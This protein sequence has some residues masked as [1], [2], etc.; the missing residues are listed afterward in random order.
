[1]VLRYPPDAAVIVAGIPGAGKSTLIASVAIGAQATVLDTDPRRER[2]AARLPVPYRLWRPLLHAA[3]LWA[4]WRAL[5]RRG[6]VVIGEPGTRRIVRRALL[7]RARR[8]GHTVHLLGID[9]TA[10]EAREGQR[11]RG[12]SIRAGSLARHARRWAALR[13]GARLE[14]FDTVRLLRR[15]DAARVRA[16]AFAPAAA[17]PGAVALCA[18]VGGRRRAG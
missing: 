3:H 16:L 17:S 5:G 12:R 14:G 7:R 15:A 2:W 4:A 8:R 1:M 9:A 13:H 11:S 18:G 6:A 10:D